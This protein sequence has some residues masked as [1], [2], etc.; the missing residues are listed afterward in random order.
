MIARVSRRD[1]WT[2][3]V[4]ISSGRK[5]G[6]GVAALKT[7]RFDAAKYLT[8]REAQLEYTTAAYETGDR[9]FIRDAYKIVARARG[10]G[11]TLSAHPAKSGCKRQKRSPSAA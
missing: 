7:T 10:L 3:G 9:E 1:N 11:I 8:T 6:T 5:T 4:A 2:R